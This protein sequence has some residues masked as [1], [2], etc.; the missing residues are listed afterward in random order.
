MKKYKI[1]Q[2]SIAELAVPIL[3]LLA[4]IILTGLGNHFIDGLY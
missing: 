4:V 1:R 3:A 2:N